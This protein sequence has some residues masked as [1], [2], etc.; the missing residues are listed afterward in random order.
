MT[1]ND[2][3]KLIGVELGMT[4]AMSISAGSLKLIL[5]GRV[6]SGNDTI[7][8]TRSYKMKVIVGAFKN[9]KKKKEER[10]G[11]EMFLFFYTTMYTAIC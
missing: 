2:L 8:T 7:A 6:L 4:E 1:A 9:K 11:G 3:K 5:K 10:R